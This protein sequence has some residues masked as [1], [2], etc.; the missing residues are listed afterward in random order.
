LR[1]HRV[2]NHRSMPW[3]EA[4]SRVVHAKNAGQVSR[5]CIPKACQTDKTA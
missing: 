3:H 5:F 2:F 1:A 4:R